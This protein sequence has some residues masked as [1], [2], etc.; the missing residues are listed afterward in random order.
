MASPLSVNQ[1]GSN[2]L[3]NFEKRIGEKKE[4]KSNTQSKT[5][6]FTW[7]T[8][9]E[10]KHVAAHK[11]TILSERLQEKKWEPHSCSAFSMR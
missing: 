7:K 2:L 6:N 10:K 11:F 8:Q 1:Q 3:W 4:Y 9:V 5:L